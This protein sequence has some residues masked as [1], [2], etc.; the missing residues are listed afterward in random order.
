[1]REN[2]VKPD[3]FPLPVHLEKPATLEHW[4]RCIALRLGIANAPQDDGWKA[5]HYRSVVIADNGTDW[6]RDKAK[7]LG[8]NCVT[9]FE[10]FELADAFNVPANAA[11]RKLAERQSKG[12]YDL[13]VAARELKS[14]FGAIDAERLH[15]AFEY[16]LPVL[17]NLA[18]DDVTLKGHFDIWL[19]AMRDLLAKAAGPTRLHRIDEDFL[20]RCHSM[21]VLAA[22]DLLTWRELTGAT[23]SDALIATW[24]WPD[25]GP[26]SDGTFVAR[27]E[28]LRKT[29]KPLI[30][31]V[32][33]WPT[34]ERLEQRQAE[35]DFINAEL[36]G[37]A[38][39]PEQKSQ[40]SIPE[41][42]Q[43]A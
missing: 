38:N 12:D 41:Q 40:K 37:R 29:T 10:A 35:T 2:N 24:L 4:A 7:L 19:R 32:M 3:W 5:A 23:Y 26:L 25:D 30:E 22:F 42:G 1:V 36:Q 15:D 21:R 39:I 13:S 14:S 34:I 16:R 18:L 43:A 6:T 20:E 11:I 27:S 17:V 28:R 33:Q 8:V 9:A 31:A